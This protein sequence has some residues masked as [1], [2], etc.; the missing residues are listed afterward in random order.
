MLDS[1]T[2]EK[3]VS[4]E[5]IKR[6][7]LEHCIEVLKPNTPTAKAEELIKSEAEMHKSVMEHNTDSETKVTREDFDMVLE[8]LKDRNK[9]SYDFLIRAGVSRL[10]LRV[11]QKN[12]R[13]R[14]FSGKV[15]RN[16]IV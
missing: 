11:L 4:V 2:G 10:N 8:K 3:V 7:N 5:E 1:K 13:G 14:M 16:D 15:C 9:R 6:V 12:D